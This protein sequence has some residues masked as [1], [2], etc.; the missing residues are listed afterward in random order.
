MKMKVWVLGTILLISLVAL[1][2]FLGLRNGFFKSSSPTAHA[3]QPSIIR[4]AVTDVAQYSETLAQLGDY[5]PSRH[6]PQ[7]I[8][9]DA[10]EVRFYFL[11]S[12]LQGGTIMQL[13]LKL[14]VDQIDELYSQ[15]GNAAIHTFVGGD[16]NIHANLPDGVPTTF[17]YTSDS[18][19]PSFPVTYEI[20]VLGAEPYGKPDL[21][22]NHGISY[23]VA[24]DKSSSVIVYWLE[25]W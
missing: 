22:W 19:Q 18:D 20:I 6:F 13:R 21:I 24:I 14:P 9:P 1:V 25:D 7:T 15:F 4:G 5:V 10:T 11:P 3:S 8:P 17:F 16:T 23:G 12:F 2:G